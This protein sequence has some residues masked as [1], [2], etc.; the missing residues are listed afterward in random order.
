MMLLTAVAV[1]VKQVVDIQPLQML[2]VLAVMAC[3]VSSLGKD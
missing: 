1:L 2:A 3:A